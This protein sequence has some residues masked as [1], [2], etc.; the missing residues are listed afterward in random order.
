MDLLFFTTWVRPFRTSCWI[1][2]I[3]IL[4]GLKPTL[5]LGI[6]KVLYIF[7]LSNTGFGFFSRNF[8]SFKGKTPYLCQKSMRIF[9]S[10]ATAGIGHHLALLSIQQGHDLVFTGSSQAGIQDAEQSFKA[11]SSHSVKGFAVDFTDLNQ[12]TDFI[13]QAFDAQSLPDVLVF[14]AGQY[15]EG[16]LHQDG[17]GHIQRQLRLH[18]LHITE[19]LEAWLPIMKERKAGHIIG[20]NSIL[21]LE[22]RRSAPGYC[23][24]KQALLQYFR[25]LQPELLPFGIRVSQVLP[26]STASRSWQ[27][28]GVN[29]SDLLN[30]DEVA[31][32]IAQFWSSTSNLRPSELILRPMS[33]MY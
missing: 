8:V 23:M 15:A 22:P 14:N 26:S 2:G 21:A 7:Q 13:S 27:G 18:F 31:Q 10:G 17:L 16:P 28:S 1:V 9:I 20:V 19:C 30:T 4:Y 32:W 24:S 12:T 33:S 29:E 5:H 25:A 6:A 3:S 11:R